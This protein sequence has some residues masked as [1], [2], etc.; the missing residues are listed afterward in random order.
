MKYF[1]KYFPVEGKIRQGDKYLEDGLILIA[2]EHKDYYNYDFL[3][4]VRLFLCSTDIQVGNN[5]HFDV[6][7][8]SGERIADQDDID[9]LHLENNPFKVI[10]PISP[11]ATWVKEGDEFNEDQV[12]REV[13]RNNGIG[14]S[15]MVVLNHKISP[16][17]KKVFGPMLFV[18]G[19]CS[20]FH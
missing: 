10:G 12:K 16:T 18:K 2:T 8:A 11:E 15:E 7:Y 13:I 17:S 20:H 6:G 1:A 19:P 5:Y 9:Q 14:R 3:K 4:K